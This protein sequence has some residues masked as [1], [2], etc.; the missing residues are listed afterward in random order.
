MKSYYL[1]DGETQ[2]GPFTLKELKA[3]QITPNSR[4]WCQEEKDWVRAADLKELKSFFPAHILNENPPVL[5]KFSNS[6]EPSRNLV[7]NVDANRTEFSEFTPTNQPSSFRSDTADLPLQSA[8]NPKLVA[9]S[10]GLAIVIILSLINFSG[11]TASVSTTGALI[12]V[13]DEPEK[14]SDKKTNESA[15]SNSKNSS[16]AESNN[17][18]STDQKNKAFRQNWR[19]YITQKP[20]KYK[21]RP[22]GGI[23]GLE[24]SV[25]NNSERIID[26]V[27]VN[28][29][30]L[31]NDGSVFDTKEISFNNIQPHSQEQVKVPNTQRGTKIKTEIAK[32]TSR[33][34]QFCYNNSSSI[35]KS[36]AD[37]WFCK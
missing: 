31:K 9:F 30:Y 19:N 2:L 24:I 35:S 1:L 27:V 29:T 14:T 7:S 15:T 12:I 25:N 11:G 17:G 28:V 34:Y 18:S 4:V 5:P 26:E 6:E 23:S 16:S 20:N 3:Q 10:L 32:I 13:E 36:L 22:L 33:S 37:P 21:S 8:I